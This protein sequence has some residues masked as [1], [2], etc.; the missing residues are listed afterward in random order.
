MAKKPAASKASAQRAAKQKA[1]E[2]KR[3]DHLK[4]QRAQR[5]LQQAKDLVQSQTAAA[6]AAAATTA[7]E[8]KEALQPNPTT[9]AAQEQHVDAGGLAALPSVVKHA[10]TKKLEIP[11]SWRR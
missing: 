5:R 3:L 2:R 9:P 4:D 7:S 8:K 1:Y 10:I 6:A 11:A